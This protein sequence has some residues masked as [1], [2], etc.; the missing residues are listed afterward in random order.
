MGKVEQIL[1]DNGEILKQINE[2]YE[3]LQDEDRKWR[4]KI[5]PGPHASNNLMPMTEK[6]P[7][8]MLFSGYFPLDENGQIIIS[9]DTDDTI[10]SGTFL[11]FFAVES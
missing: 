5:R 1:A 2:I 7:K 11:C 4:P 6:Q 8:L 10:S 9:G 3:I